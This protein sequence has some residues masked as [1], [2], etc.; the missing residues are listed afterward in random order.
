MKI[1]LLNTGKTTNKHLLSLMSDYEKR[2]SK[3]T[4]FQI[5]Q[6]SDIQ[7]SSSA[8]A[9]IIQEK[10]YALQ[11]K[12]LSEADYIVLFDETGKQFSSGQFAAYFQKKQLENIKHLV[13]I[14]GGSYGFSTQLRAKA[15]EN[16]S[17][18]LM[19]FP[20]QLVRLIIIEQIYRAFTIL[21]HEKYHH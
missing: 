14:T 21:H 9:Q 3:Y 11:Q 12:F 7:F 1:T 19:T 8:N 17:L 16:I 20:H 4:T 18:S 10:E 5:I 2:I 6:T 13:F 15:K